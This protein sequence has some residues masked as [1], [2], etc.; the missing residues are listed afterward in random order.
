[1]AEERACDVCGRAEAELPPR[2][3]GSGAR[4]TVDADGLW[5]CGDCRAGLVTAPVGGMADE[6]EALPGELRALVGQQAGW[7]VSTLNLPYAPPYEGLIDHA[8]Q[9]QRGYRSPWAFVTQ[10]LDGTTVWRAPDGAQ[11]AYL[12]A[13]G[14]L[15]VE[16][17]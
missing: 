12:D 4:L 14:G 3:A 1:M 11:V 17:R 9:M 6:A 16:D 7:I 15:R 2:E 10:W 13:E 8:R 5:L